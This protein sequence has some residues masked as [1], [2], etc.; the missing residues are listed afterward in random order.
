MRHSRVLVTGGSGAIGRG[1]CE[2]AARLG[3]RVGFTWNRN[4]QG[5]AQTEAALRAHES[6][7]QAIQVDLSTPDGSARALAAMAERWDGIDVLVNNAGASE[8]IPFML[9]EDREIRELLGLNFMAPLR[10]MRGA[11][12][13]MVR[14]R[15]GR[16]VNISSIAGSRTIPG[17]VHY[18]ASKGA[19]EGLTRSLAHELGPYGI[20]V[21]AVGL[22]MFEGGV[23]A[24][25]PEHHQK[26]YL[27][28][29]ALNRAGTALECGE[30]VCWLGSRLN[31]YV[32]G[33]VVYQDGATVC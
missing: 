2:V 8:A 5:R 23:R 13:F 17:P 1:I 28:A 14:Q 24:T 6:E 33:T 19:L 25:V 22:G 12:R 26:R 16:I 18:S 9:L 30:L 11:A 7:F 4:G 20:L 10:L 29:C 21:N 31:T 3:A 27:D 15:F 32:N